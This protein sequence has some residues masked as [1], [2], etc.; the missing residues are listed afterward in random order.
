MRSNRS[1][2]QRPEPR[3]GAVISVIWLA[4]VLLSLNTAE[5]SAASATQILMGA[6]AFILPIALIWIA[7]LVAISLDTMRAESAHLRKSMETM[8]FSLTGEAGIEAGNRAA[9]IQSQLE[10]LAELA[11]TNDI[12]LSALAE[13]SFQHTGQPLPPRESAALALKGNA[14]LRNLDQP[15]LPLVTESRDDAAP[16][17]VSEFIRA[18]NFPH[19]AD[20]KEGF[21]ILRRV[22]QD[23][24]VGGLIER[25][26]EILTLLAEDGIYMD[27][28]QPDKPTARAWRAFVKGTRGPDI[29]GLGGIRDKSALSLARA[30][31][32]NDMKFRDRT[33]EF[34]RAFDRVLIE[35]EK[36]AEDSEILQ[37]GDTR[38]ARVFM[39]LGRVSGTFD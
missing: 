3:I 17:S 36:T 32:K 35:F 22:L 16:I 33:H 6:V 9:E 38:S 8:Q 12:R 13:Q 28:L 19:D 14:N 20:D 39:L 34:L 31:L 7:V 24:D 18:M 26:K 1:F 21:R 5:W 4:V 2:F 15:D 27:D 11:K 25:A 29:A 10:T 30:R 37:M 23:R